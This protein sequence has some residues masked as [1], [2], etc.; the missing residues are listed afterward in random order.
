MKKTLVALAVLGTFAG[1]AHAQSNVT[2]WGIITGGVRHV[3]NVGTTAATAD[4]DR[5]GMGTYRANRFGIK[6]V[7]DIGGGLQA[8]FSLENG[9][10][11][12]TGEMTNGVLW[13]RA[14]FVGL[15]GPWGAVDIGRQTTIAF[16]VVSIYDPFEYKYGSILPPTQAGV[17]AGARNNNEIQ[18]A[19]EFGGLTAR[20]GYAL[21]EVAGDTSAG[22]IKTVGFSYGDGPWNVGGVYTKRNPNIG[23]V[24][25]PSYRNN[26]HFT[27]GGAYETGP[28]KFFVGYADEKQ[29]TTA[30]TGD[31]TTKWSW[32]G[33][34]YKLT[35]AWSVTAAHYRTKLRTAGADGTRG[36]SMIGTG[37]SL[38]K[39]TTLFAE[40]DSLKLAGAERGSAT[41]VPFGQDRQTGISVGIDH[42][43]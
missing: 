6:G 40:V 3:T 19:V 38:S 41:S 33:A 9:F 11:I 1:M 36:L 8:Y 26:D 42:V 25:A 15:K 4:G 32:L 2:I 20:A 13:Q 39:R 7:E 34:K 22:S 5:L 28:F 24:A 16:K 21:G 30:V 12:G 23:T 27:V 29:E 18:Y 35:P 10:N 14:A 17:A 43:F 31:N 37:Y